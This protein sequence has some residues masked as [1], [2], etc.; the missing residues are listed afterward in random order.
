MFFERKFFMKKPFKALALLLSL[1]ILS[2]SASVSC[3]AAASESHIPSIIVPGIFQSEVKYYE[4][5]EVALNSEG[6]EYQKPFF[7]DPTKEV[8]ADAL[9]TAL[10]PISKLLISQKDKDE[11]AAN[12]VADVLARTLMEKQ[13][14]DENGKFIND[15]RATKYYDSVKDLS[16]YDRE[17]IFNQLP[18]QD[19]CNIAGEENLYVFSYASLGNMIDT[20]K[21]L[22]DFISFVKKDSGSDKVNLVPISQG[23]SVANALLQLYADNNRSLS[24]DVHRI[25][26]IVPALDGSL[27]LGDIFEYGLLDD[28]E[29]LYKKMFPALMGEDYTAYLVNIIIRIFPNAD[30]NNILDKAVEKLVGD[31]MRFST[32]LWGLVPSGNYP[33]CRE[34]YLNDEISTEIRRQADWYYGAQLNSDKNILN[35][36]N[37]GVEIFDVVDYN[38]YLYEICDS[39]NKVN[40]DGIIQLDSTSMGAF[41]LG[42]DVQLPA[43]YTTPAELN[44]CSD[45][46]H[47]DHSDPNNIVDPCT[48]LLPETTFYFF[49]QNH[50]KTASND[51]IMKLAAA[52][53][54]DDSFKTVYSRP[55]EF[56]QFNNGRNAKGFMKDLK[57]FE[58]LDVSALSPELRAEYDRVIEESHAALNNTVLAPDDFEQAK[59]NFYSVRERINCALEG[60]E[61]SD[62][63]NTSLSFDFTAVLTK[64]LKVASD[65]LYRLFKG[66]GF[67]EMK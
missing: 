27:L 46:A 1:V 20:A 2:A 60:K 26:Y 64:L 39:W 49:N 44:N 52:L 38:E 65:I 23:G 40:A 67:S 17:Y 16:D 34:I 3:F 51:I 28:D 62:S 63:G 54:T 57:E 36:V 19:Y 8:V 31:Y 22:Y 21:E 12:A 6:E 7:I 47:H 58:K 5:G 56:P 33:G 45:P 50:E 42:V 55:N 9:T 61:P 14:C 25:V 48:G 11:M 59:A 30:L 66:L 10:V 18:L 53:L 13:K 41:S 29:E 32:L 15:I 24:K 37:D 35:A 4:N 43:E